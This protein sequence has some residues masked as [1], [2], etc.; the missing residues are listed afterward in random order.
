NLRQL[1]YMAM[2]TDPD[3]SRLPEADRA[4]VGRALSREPRDRHPS[5]L[6]FIEALQAVSRPGSSP[7]IPALRPNSTSF[8]LGLGDMAATAAVEKTRSTPS[9]GLYQRPSRMV[10]VVR[11]GTA[12]SNGDGLL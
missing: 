10:P 12:P 11:P 6:A 3:L 7:C 1:A 8:D 2:T 9:S 4:I 5:C